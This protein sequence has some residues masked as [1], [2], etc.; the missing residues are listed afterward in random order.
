MNYCYLFNGEEYTYLSSDQIYHKNTKF[1][2]IN[3]YNGNV[4]DIQSTVDNRSLIQLDDYR[5][6]LC[7]ESTSKELFWNLRQE[8]IKKIA[9]NQFN[10]FI[11]TTCGKVYSVG[12]DNFGTMLPFS[13]PEK[14]KPDQARLVSHFIKNGIFIKDIGCSIYTN[15]FLDN[16]GNL[17]SNGNQDVFF[18]NKKSQEIS[19]PK[20]ISYG[21]EKF[22]CSA[23]SNSFFFIKKDNECLYVGGK[24][25]AYQLGLRYKYNPTEDY[26]KFKDFD[27][28]DIKKISCA[29]NHTII[30]T[31][32]GELY[33]AGDRLYTCHTD[34]SDMTKFHKIEA[35]QE[36]KIVDIATGITSSYVL[37]DNNELYGWGNFDQENNFGTKPIKIEIPE[38]DQS[39]KLKISAKLEACF[40]N[41]IIQDP[42]IYDFKN[43]LK[44]EIF[45]D[46]QISNRK[47]HK[48]LIEFRLKKKAE[49]LEKL[50]LQFTKGE[51]NQF[52]SYIYSGQIKD[53]NVSTIEK[54]GKL[55]SSTFVIQNNIQNDLMDLYSQDDSKDFIILV[56]KEKI[57]QKNNNKKEEEEKEKNENKSENKKKEEKKVEDDQKKKNENKNEKGLIRQDE[58]EKE[59]EKEIN[60]KEEYFKSETKEIKVHKLILYARSDLYRNIFKFSDQKFNQIKDYSGISFD[61]LNVL[62]KFLYSEDLEWSLQNY[63]KK[64]QIIN[65]LEGAQEYFLLNK[66]SSL[67]NQLIHMK[68]KIIFAKIL[69]ERNILSYV[70]GNLSTVI[71][72]L[73][74]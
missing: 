63:V 15:Y 30:L 35:F 52:I 18:R 44:H 7:S 1:Y 66:Y 5:L 20:Y 71:E 14:C 61:G 16:E 19:V 27:I 11:L 38:C 48:L 32:K 54:I 23:S 9:C 39:D 4:V 2:P 59:K 46:Y 42:L 17:Y 8:K 25:S 41:R 43:L 31:K 70:S 49:D 29:L 22:F 73:T 57:N 6:I 56:P 12:D 51:I 55:I 37:T 26:I 74:F 53:N 60:E 45:T 13:D 33:S 58:G 50:L 34:N 21:N 40:L 24:N 36:K 3:E 62:I 65:E 69:E 10:F 68:R 64:I 67:K 72:S 47:V 28:V